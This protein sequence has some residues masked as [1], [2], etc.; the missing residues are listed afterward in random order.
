MTLDSTSLAALNALTP[1]TISGDDYW[2]D[3]GTP[4]TLA[5]NGVWNRA[6]GSGLRLSSYALNGGSPCD[7]RHDVVR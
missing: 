5:L 3:T 6:S 2:Y 4:V 1:P 7:G